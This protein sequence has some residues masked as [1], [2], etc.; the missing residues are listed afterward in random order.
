MPL[1]CL[2]N[3]KEI[4]AFDIA[5]EGEW[6]MLREAN[7]RQE[8]L[9]M[10]CCG[11]SV[12]LR[13]S[14]LGTR[15]FAHRRVGT[16]V[17]KPESAEHLLAKMIIAQSAKR[18]GWTATT[19]HAGQTAEG[20]SWVADVLV[21]KHG[22]KPLA[23]EVQWTRQTDDET[24]ARQDRYRKSDVRALWLLR[25]HDFPISKEVPAFRLTFDENDN[26]FSVGVPNQSLRFVGKR[27]CNEAL[28]WQQVIPLTEFIAGALEGRLK[29]APALNESIPATVWTT[30]KFC[31]K[32]G[33]ETKIVNFI[34]LNFGRIFPGH[35]NCDVTIYDFDEWRQGRALL[36]SLL[37]K[38]LL[39][40]HNIGEVKPRFGGWGS[41]PMISNG[42]VHCGSLHGQFYDLDDM[43]TLAPGPEIQIRLD[44]PLLEGM[45]DIR[46]FIERWW[47]QRRESDNQNAP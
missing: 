41:S 45:H 16:C 36:L 29:F 19:E 42:C 7:S 20:E 18:Q 12:T 23:F 43:D 17:T 14:K 46:E 47:F 33:C 8:Q 15:H 3:G 26:A 27:E 9:T 40:S 10:P 11:S 6:Q 21:R 25:Q 22:M 37:P 44:H 2:R 4:F 31:Y 34:T 38:D 32:C 13:K 5:D 35:P 39:A 28:H 30:E 1:K 24:Q